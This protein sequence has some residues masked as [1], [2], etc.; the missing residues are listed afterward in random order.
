MP[1]ESVQKSTVSL[2]KTVFN[3]P[4][5]KKFTCESWI[6]WSETRP[7][8]WHFACAV[9]RTKIAN[10]LSCSSEGAPKNVWWYRGS[11]PGRTLMRVLF[12]YVLALCIFAFSAVLESAENVAVVLSSDAAPYQEALEG[13]REVVRHRIA[14]VQI[15]Q[16]DNPTGWQQQLTRLRSVIEPDLISLWVH[17]LCNS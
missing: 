4:G 8:T 1:P 17:R 5:P 10:D 6:G 7:I 3:R 9:R 15:L 16:K 11:R 12:A 2:A 14:G 13:F